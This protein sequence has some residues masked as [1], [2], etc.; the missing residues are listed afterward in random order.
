VEIFTYLLVFTERKVS[1]PWDCNSN[2]FLP[3]LPTM[4]A[5]TDESELI[6]II[7]SQDIIV[8]NLYQVKQVVEK[9]FDMHPLLAATNRIDF[10]GRNPI[11]SSK[12][13]T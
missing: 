1:V 5:I 7:S 3:P 6:R 10:D 11:S 4:M 9:S 2:I 13:H 12:A 8:P